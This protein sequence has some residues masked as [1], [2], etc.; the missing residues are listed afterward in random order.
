MY[1][2]SVPEPQPSATY[3]IPNVCFSMHDGL[4]RD[5]V[6]GIRNTLQKLAL[7][8]NPGTPTYLPVG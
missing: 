6:H 1:M 3:S 8:P 2:A 4:F 5:T 7:E